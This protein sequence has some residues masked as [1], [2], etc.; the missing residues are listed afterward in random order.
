MRSTK[1]I[2]TLGPAVDTEEAMEKLIAGG[3][4]AARFNFSHGS[5]ESQLETYERLCRVRERLNRPVAAILDTKGP[6]IRLK[7]FAGGSIELAAGDTFTLTG[8]EIMGDSHAVS[9]THTVL[10]HEVKSGDRILVDDGLVELRV[11]STEDLDIHCTVVN[12]GALSDHK[13]MNLPD[14]HIS[15]PA[16]TEKDEAD[17]AFAAAHGFDWIAASFIRSKEDV[18]SLKA[19]LKA[20]GGESIRI[21]AKIE[22]REGVDRLEEILDAVDG[23][24]V[25]R[26]DLGVEI[27]AAE[28]PVVQKRMVSLARKKGKTVVIATQML[29][30]MIRNPRPTRAEVSDVANAIFEGA[31]CVMLSGETASGSYPF[32]ALQAMVDT[33]ECAEAS[34]DPWA[35]FRTMRT[36]AHPPVDEAISHAC[37]TTAMDLSAAAI[38]T[39]TRSGHTARNISRYRPGCPILALTPSE[40]VRRQLAICRGVTPI[41]SKEA[42]TT[43]EL[44]ALTL[45]AALDYAE[46]GNRVVITAGIPLGRA[47]NTNLIHAAT[48]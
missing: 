26:G 32:G 20:H 11:E 10:A 34:L 19:V 7:D 45:S 21:M 47:A 39:M 24:M 13:S 29:D 14:V 23:V 16:I 42:D 22:N 31:D 30:S 15:L 2:C 1:I 40:Q 28:V 17:L 4:N 9:I 8:R 6:E 12:G 41:R 46:P 43:D 35:R 48:L 44:I 27:P 5:H 3:M 37:C 25:A 38:V 33:I 36:E 18:D